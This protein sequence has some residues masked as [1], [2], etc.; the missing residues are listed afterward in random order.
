MFKSSTVSRVLVETAVTGTL[1]LTFTRVICREK[2]VT[3]FLGGLIVD[4]KPTAQFSVPHLAYDALK[5]T[6]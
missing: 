3:V 4:S 1:I 2:N 6:L 5:T